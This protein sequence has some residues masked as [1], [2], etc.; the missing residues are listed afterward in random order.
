MKIKRHRKSHAYE[1]CIKSFLDDPINRTKTMCAAYKELC[2]IDIS[3]STFNRL[4][5]RLGYTRKRM[6][7]KVLGRRTQEQINSYICRYQQVMNSEPEIVVSVDES[8]FSEKYMP[9]YGYCKKGTRCIMRRS[10]GGWTSHSLILSIASDGSHHGYVKKG[11]CNREQ[12]GEYILDMPYPPGTVLILDNCSIHKGLDEVYEAKGYVPLFLSPYSPDFQPVEL[13]FSKIKG[14]FRH[15][16]DKYANVTDQIM[17]C[18]GELR[19][20]DIAGYFQC[21]QRQLKHNG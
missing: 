1:A 12:F 6:S 7:N 13:A 2:M 4:Y 3:L 18:V 11:A 14:I 17:A 9:L 16:H 5:R 21:A 15:S 10:R 20:S 8:N 19:A